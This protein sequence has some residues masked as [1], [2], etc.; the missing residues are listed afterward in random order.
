MKRDRYL[1]DLSSEHHQALALARDIR[2]VTQGG[3]APEP[4]IRHVLKVY[5]EELRPHFDVE[6]QAILP[7]LAEAG[8]QALAERTLLEHRQIAYLVEHLEIDDNLERFA[9]AL[10][11]HVRFEERILFETCQRKL[12]E[13]ALAVVAAHRRQQEDAED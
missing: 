2:K 10:K 6:E 3:E 11:E 7:A 5:R 12:D 4:M 1:R 9:H 13:S 8:E